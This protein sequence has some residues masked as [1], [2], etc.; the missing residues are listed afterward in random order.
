MTI[1]IIIKGQIDSRALY[2]KLSPY[3]NVTDLIDKTF[4][5]ATIDLRE[6]IVEYIINTCK[7]YGECDIETHK[8]KE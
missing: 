4:V 8:I 7:S 3:A 2:M 5:H 6:D 1:S